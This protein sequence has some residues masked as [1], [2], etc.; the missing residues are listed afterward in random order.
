MA[1]NL[2]NVAGTL[3]FGT[4][5][6]GTPQALLNLIASYLSITGGA[7]F[8]PVNFGSTTPTADNRDKPWFQ[9]D[10]GGVPI[11]WFSWNG[12]TWEQM[13]VSVLYGNTASRPAG[14]A[15]KL[16]YFDTDIN[17]L[18]VYERSAWRTADGCPGDIKFV[19]AALL[20]TALTNNPGWIQD[21]DSP[22]RVV[23]AAGDGSGLTPRA[24]GDS[25][26]EEAH[27]Q[28]VAELPAHNHSAGA[29][30]QMQADGNVSHSGGI[31][32]SSS[33]GNTGST[34]D[35]DAFN[36]MQPTIFYWCLVKQ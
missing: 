4:A 8:I 25:I 13:P 28:T 34:G 23:G 21:P 17:C 14:G 35:G 1:L 29:V 27:T 15:A 31:L 26:G 33:Q 36:V 2:S 22:G 32:G 3:P 19:K 20:S 11:G 12:T 18:L 30:S 24:Y 6:P 7:G 16:L 10:S 9:T 5:F